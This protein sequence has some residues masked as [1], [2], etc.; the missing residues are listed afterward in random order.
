VAVG[1]KNQV[2][3]VDLGRV[4]L[5]VFVGWVGDPGVDQQHLA[6]GCPDLERREPVPGEFGIPGDGGAGRAFS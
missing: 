6:A 1:D 4:L 5:V 2:D 3:T